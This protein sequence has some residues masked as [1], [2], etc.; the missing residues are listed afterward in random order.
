MELIETVLVPGNGG[1]QILCAGVGMERLACLIAQG[2]AVLHPTNFLL[3][4]LYS[5]ASF[6][7]STAGNHGEWKKCTLKSVLPFE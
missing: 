2:E 4:V 7:Y 1:N 3:G 5:A 6:Q